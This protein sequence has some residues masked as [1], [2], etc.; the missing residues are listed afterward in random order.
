MQAT[1]IKWLR[2]EHG[3]TRKEMAGRTGYSASYIEKVE[4]GY[5]RIHAGIERKFMQALGISEQQALILKLRYAD[6]KQAA[7]PQSS[8]AHLS[9]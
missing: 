4:Q 7:A 8:T 5:A 3:L 6:L 1:F 9:L 2:Q